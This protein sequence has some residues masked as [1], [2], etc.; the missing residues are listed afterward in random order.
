[1]HTGSS[2]RN[3]GTDNPPKC[4]AGSAATLIKQLL[5]GTN[6]SAMR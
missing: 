1:M 6:L 3:P 5:V 4:L 2:V